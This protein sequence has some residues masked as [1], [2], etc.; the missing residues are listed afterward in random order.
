MHKI[1]SPHH[2][3]VIMDGNGRWATQRKLMRMAG[4]VKG[5]K[6]VRRLVENCIK[7][8]IK[9]LTIFAFS[10]ENWRRPKDE[11]SHLMNL[12]LSTLSK[13][14]ARLHKNNVNISFIGDRSK[15]SIKLNDQ[16]DRAEK[17]TVNNT[18][19]KLVVAVNYSGHWDITQAMK[20]VAEKIS[21][22][23]IS[24]E[25]IDEELISNHSCLAHLP[26]PDLLIR[27]GGEHRISNFLLWQ[28]ASSEIYF[29]D[30]LWPDFD[31][32]KF[33]DA[34]SWYGLQKN[35]FEATEGF[36]YSF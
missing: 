20:K 13:Q 2:I 26:N 34:C 33:S 25:D 21:N 18:G 1:K 17:I 31:D 35:N 32:V 23:E 7:H 28:L 10:R 6:A 30:V 29:T 5:A 8:D 19:L 12:F 4:H 27:T 9:I 11:V 16:M 22:D 36:G 24:L 3:A 14:M 15:F